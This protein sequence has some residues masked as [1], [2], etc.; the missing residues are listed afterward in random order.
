[1]FEFFVLGI[2]T[3][4]LALKVKQKYL[5]S[6]IYSFSYAA[7]VACIDEFIQQFTGRGSRFSDVI[8]DVCG[9]MIAITLVLFCD[10]LKN[11]V[12]RKSKVN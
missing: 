11:R 3:I 12:H 4:L 1:M 7:I 6:I 2:F 10:F 8:I 9:A 5:I